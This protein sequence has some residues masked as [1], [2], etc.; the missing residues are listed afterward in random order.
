MIFYVDS[1]LSVTGF[2]LLLCINTF[3]VKSLSNASMDLSIHAM[4]GGYQ[5]SKPVLF[6]FLSTS[7]FSRVVN[8][9]LALNFFL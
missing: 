5:G 2:F 6:R 8:N 4:S 9:F 7:I 3:I 1:S